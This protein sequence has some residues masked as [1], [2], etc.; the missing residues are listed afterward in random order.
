MSDLLDA[1]QRL[2]D[3]CA[4]DDERA[5]KGPWTWT[6]EVFLWNQEID[7]G[8]LNHG[9]TD[10]PVSEANRDVIA[11][12]RN[13][14]PELVRVLA[15]ASRQI[16]LLS[17]LAIQDSAARD[18][19]RSEILRLEALAQEQAEKLRVAEAIRDDARAASQR[20]LDEKRLLGSPDVER[21]TVRV[22][23][24]EKAL[25]RAVELLGVDG[26][27]ALRYR[28]DQAAPLRAVLDGKPE[29]T[30]DA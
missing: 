13:R 15:G 20:Y 8:I 1:M 19:L 18:R 2:I 27:G 11:A 4:R 9:G 30:I 21:L 5:T 7:Q 6:D 17:N 12:A 3:A 29:G 28:L 26:P 24:L 16:D 14:L 22:Q 10:W 25:G 23:E